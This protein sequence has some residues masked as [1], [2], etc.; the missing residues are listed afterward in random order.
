[1]IAIPQLSRVAGSL[2]IFA[3]GVA[4]A[5]MGLGLSYLTH[6]FQAEY[7]A[8]LEWV[9]GTTSTVPGPATTRS[10]RLRNSAHVL[11]VIAFLASIGCFIYGMLS[12]RAAI[13][14]LTH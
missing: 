13:E 5:V 12:V 9:A 11:A 7:L 14:H 6:F 3:F 4:A 8:S 1:L 2:E 10:L